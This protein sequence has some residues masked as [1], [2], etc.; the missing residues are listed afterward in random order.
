MQQDRA[1]LED[2]EVAIGQ[3]RHLAERLVREMFGAAPVER[4]ARDAIGQ[5]GL[6]ECPAHPEVAHETARGRGNPVEG[7]QGEV[8]HVASPS[9]VSSIGRV[10]DARSDTGA[11]TFCRRGSSPISTATGRM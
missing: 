7:G 2:R 4:R 3:P 6:F 10:R 8:G 5:C 9:A 11:N 1:A